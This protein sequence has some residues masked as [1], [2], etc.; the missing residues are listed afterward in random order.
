MENFKI[1]VLAFGIF[2]LTACGNNISS[3]PT[4][5][6]VPEVVTNLEDKAIEVNDEIDLFF[7]PGDV[8]FTNAENFYRKACEQ[9][10]LLDEFCIPE[11]VSFSYFRP[12]DIKSQNV[13]YFDVA[14]LGGVDASQLLV[15]EFKKDAVR[16]LIEGSEVLS[17]NI[18]LSPNNE[19]FVIVDRSVNENNQ[20]L[21]AVNVET[22]EVQLLETQDS[23]ASFISC[24]SALFEMGCGFSSETK[25]IDEN[26]FQVQTMVLKTEE[27]KIVLDE[28]LSEI[29]VFEF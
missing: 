19:S 9:N 14:R 22:A 8:P 16:L 20:K 23:L 21:Y 13:R 18:K 10:I 1:S 6:A 3:A 5:E 27:G 25:W 7:D 4:A 2:F 24:D 17:S 15:Y 28:A 26:T 11:A 29:K 12:D